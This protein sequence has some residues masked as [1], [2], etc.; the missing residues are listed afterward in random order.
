MPVSGFAQRQLNQAK[1]EESEDN[2]NLMIGVGAIV[3]IF[4]IAA[5]LNRIFS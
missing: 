3:S 2:K 4:I 1:Q 5:I